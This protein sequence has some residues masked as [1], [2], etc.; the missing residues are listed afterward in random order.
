[1]LSDLDETLKQLLIQ[2]VPI[3][4]AKVNISFDIPNREWAASQSKPTVNVYLYD[5][6]ENHELRSYDWTVERNQNRT[7]TR[8]KAPTR[9]DLAYTLSIWTKDVADEH[10]LL[11]HILVALMRCPVVPED[12]LQGA[13]KG[14]EYPVH[15]ST[16]QPDGLFK[17]PADFWTAL[18]NQLKPSLNYVVTL[19]V[20]L[21][22]AFTAPLVW[23]KTIEVREKEKETIEE[24]VQIGGRVHKKEKPDAGIAHAL[25]VAKEAG[26][27]TETDA[28]GNYTFSK[29]QKGRYTF[30][31]SV[32][33]KPAHEIE[34]EIPSDNYNLEV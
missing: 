2:K 25:I 18:D 26:R 24:L 28:S 31:V 27:T 7:A 23:T 11:G 14:L 21:D 3:E 32:R 13:L 6:R 22:I 34:V 33:G 12:L 17:S 16:A 8:K 4:S 20:D 10:R 15:A 1:M 9:I 29:L 19:P 5:I 30:L